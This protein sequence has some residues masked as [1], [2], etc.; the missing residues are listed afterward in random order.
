MSL[1]D[2]VEKIG[3]KIIGFGADEGGSDTSGTQ[4]GSYD[5][6]ATQQQQQQQQQ[7]QWQQQQQNQWQQQQQD[8]WQQQQQQQQQSQL[9]N[10]LQQLQGFGQTTGQQQFQYGL[11]PQDQIARAGQ[12]G[13]LQQLM[14]GGGN[15][16][17]ML[18]DPASSPGAKASIATFLAV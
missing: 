13:L 11:A 12:L 16:M 9:A 15:F 14:S 17:Q 7:N 1:W 8:Q 5:T 2:S 6:R 4:T 10:V 3:K 18:N